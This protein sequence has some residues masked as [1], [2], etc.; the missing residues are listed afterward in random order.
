ME[1]ENHKSNSF[2]ENNEM[3]ICEVIN[4]SKETIISYHSLYILKKVD[5]YK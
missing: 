4:K 2:K 5:L 3:D 1:K